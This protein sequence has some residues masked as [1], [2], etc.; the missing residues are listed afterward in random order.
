MLLR[1]LGA[2]AAALITDNSIYLLLLGAWPSLS[3]VEASVP[4]YLVGIA[5]HYAI[6]RRFVFPAG[7]LHRRRLQELLLFFSTGV[8]GTAV[9]ASIVWL[10][11]LQP[12][13]GVHWP[14]IVAIAVSFLVTYVLRKVLVFRRVQI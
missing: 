14:K 8:V 2:S 10:V 9:T 4:A 7:W 5:V 11:S 6:S 12:G 3:P 1:Y 13:V